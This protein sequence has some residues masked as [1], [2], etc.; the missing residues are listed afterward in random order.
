ME[1]QGIIRKVTEPTDWVHP[2]VIVPKKTGGIRLCVDFRQLNKSI[3]RPKFETA[4]PFQ[5]VRTIPPGMRY[6]TV[7]DALKG[8][9]QVELDNDSAALT[10]FS[11][12]FGR[13]QY[14]RLPMGVSLASDDYGRRVSDVFDSLPSSRRIVRRRCFRKV[15]R[16]TQRV[17][18]KP[19]S[20]CSRKLNL[21]EFEEIGIRSVILQVWCL[22]DRRKRF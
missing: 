1:D 4:T 21:L 6:F 13:Y 15:L 5:A 7:V 9:H 16:G 22:C 14:R 18:P 3:V 19:V 8:Y 10:T 17:S 20:L 12:P 11:T 2:I